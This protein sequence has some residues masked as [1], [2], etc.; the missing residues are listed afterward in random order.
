MIE[1]LKPLIASPELPRYVQELREVLAR[2]RTLRQKF[3]EEMTE[4]QKAEFVNGQVIMHSPVQRKHG[5]ASD[6]LF[7]LVSTYV[8]QNDLGWVGH[9]K[10][11]VALTRNDYEPDVAFWK[12]ERAAEFAA[13]QMK[14]PAPDFVAEVLSPSTEKNDRGVKF[15]DYAAHG[16]S[17]YWL[18]DPAR[19]QIEKHLLRGRRFTVAETCR[20]GRIASTV[21][22]GL[23]V[24]VS[25]VFHREVNLKALRRLLARSDPTVVVKEYWIVLGSERRVEVYRRPEQ[26]SYQEQQLLEGDAELEC[27]GVPGLRLRL[28]ELFA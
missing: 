13:D 4:E 3:Y 21:I 16:V 22:A 9:E 12:A 11:L 2:E 26:G 27:A 1:L 25:A 23:V 24:P 20:K 10:L 7:K 18:V 6:F 17:E 28:A 5:L 15:E 14:F 8:D 19:E